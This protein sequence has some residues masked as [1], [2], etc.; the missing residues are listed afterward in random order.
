MNNVEIPTWITVFGWALGIF[1]LSMGA[2][3]YLAPALV[4]HGIDTSTTAGM[5]AMGSL[6]GRNL[7]M[8]VTLIVALLS[9]SPRLLKLAFIMR[10]VTEVTDLYI[11][12]TSGIYLEAFGIPTIAIIVF[13]LL[14]LILP[15]ILAIKKLSSL[16]PNN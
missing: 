2:A 16:K 12:A 3:C 8:G 7:A 11:S 5:H 4:V 15:E 9:K 13:W 1:G 6:G 14:C 10:L